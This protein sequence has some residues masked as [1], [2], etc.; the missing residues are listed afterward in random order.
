MLKITFSNY[1]QKMP[2]PKWML[3][4]PTTLLHVF[5]D[6]IGTA[7]QAFRDYDTKFAGMSGKKYP[8]PKRGK[9][10]FLLLCT[11]GFLWTTFRRWTP[12]KELYY[13]NNIGKDFKIIIDE[14]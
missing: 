1:Y 3:A 8:L 6:D 4:Y 7:L 5:I 12:K 9:F 2:A 10:M 11:N 14:T 13:V